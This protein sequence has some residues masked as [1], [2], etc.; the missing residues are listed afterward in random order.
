[1]QTVTVESLN[2]NHLRQALPVVVIVVK[3]ENFTNSCCY[4]NKVRKEIS[5]LRIHGKMLQEGLTVRKSVKRDRYGS[6]HTPGMVMTERK[7]ICLLCGRPGLNTW[8]VQLIKEKLCI[9]N[10]WVSE[11]AIGSNTVR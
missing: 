1:M 9:W 2:D 3:I 11:S 7:G 10:R 8:R 4:R 6:S 5:S